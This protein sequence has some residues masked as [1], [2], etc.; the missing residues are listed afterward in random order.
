MHTHLASTIH[1]RVRHIVKA[2]AQVG[3]FQ[4]GNVTL[5]F[6]NGLEV[7]KDLAGMAVIGQGINDRHGWKFSH[8]EQVFMFEQTRHHHIHKTG[9]SLHGITDRFLTASHW[10]CGHIIID[11]MSA[12]LGHARFKGQSC[13]QARLFKNHQQIFVR[14]SILIRCRIFLHVLGQIQHLLDLLGT[15]QFERN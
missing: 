1:Q 14:H 2:V 13:P 3:Q 15:P 11:R 7:S 12:H 10:R 9:S 4:S 5:F 6:F 8:F